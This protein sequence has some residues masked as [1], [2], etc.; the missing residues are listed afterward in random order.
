MHILLWRGCELTLGIS[1]RGQSLD[2]QLT[3]M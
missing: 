2:I 3:K 1:S